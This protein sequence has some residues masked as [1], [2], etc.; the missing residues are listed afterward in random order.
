[1]ERKKFFKIGLLGESSVGK[2]CIINSYTRNE[3]IETFPTLGIGPYNVKK[4]F[5]NSEYKF[6]IIDTSGNERD[7]S[8]TGTIMKIADG[9]VV[10]FA[11]DNRHSF[12]KVDFWI[13]NIEYLVNLEEKVLY[14]VGNKSDVEPEKRQVTKEEAESYAKCKKIKYF[15]TS[16]CT[17][18]GI[19]EVF[20]EVFKEVYEISKIN[21]INKKKEKL[22]PI[23]R[24]NWNK[25]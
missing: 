16:A 21:E 19:N 11:V 17:K 3:F 14:L 7:R 13:N 8:L 1:M 2:T 6:K 23:E 22:H 20:E 12:V 25:K 18:K 4:T 5:D 24:D 10:V 9:L 15:E